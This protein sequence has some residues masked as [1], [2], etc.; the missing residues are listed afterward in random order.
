MSTH[1]EEIGAFQLSSLDPADPSFTPLLYRQ[2]EETFLG[3][4]VQLRHG[5]YLKKFNKKITLDAQTSIDGESAL[6]IDNMMH[7]YGLTGCI[8]VRG[9]TIHLEEYRHGNTPASRNDIQ[10]I[11]KS[12]TT[13]ALAIAQ[14]E[15]RLSV[16]D[17]V[18]LHVE[19]LADTV[20][21]DVPLSALASM[22]SGVV[23]PSDDP[24]PADIPNP[25]FATKLYPS[26]DENAVLNW[27]KTFKKVAEPWEEFHYYN[28][29][30]YVMSLAISRAVQQ[31]LQDFISSR[32]W[33]PAGMQYDG[34]I[35]T[36]SA[37]QVDGHGGLSITLSDMARFGRF[38]L[39]AV[40]GGKGGA[41]VP[42]SWFSDI[43][44]A[45]NSTGARAPGANDS[46]PGFGYEAGWWTPDKSHA[47]ASE[48]GFAAIG[49][50]GQAIY[51]LPK[52]D[53]IIA[54]QSGNPDHSSEPL[55][56]N[57]ELA[58]TI[59]RMLKAETS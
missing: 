50:Y 57:I 44:S 33:E 39:D 1:A 25:M 22:S 27:L 38:V 21:A 20:W 48:G 41:P 37:G 46:L 58:T 23:E 17:P 28:P 29:N 31:P 43:S 59:V 54:V 13:T 42:H 53:A 47:L 12:F 40:D 35:R 15:G 4:T 10:S 36:T 16:N 51:I 49:M 2:R 32:I 18:S 30:F 24:R 45:K 52:L 3:R 7:Q 56:R 9:D 55:T 6:S 19:E 26:S 11:T 5:S 14:Q 8:V 34:Y